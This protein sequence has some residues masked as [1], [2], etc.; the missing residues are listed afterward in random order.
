MIGLDIQSKIEIHKIRLETYTIEK[1]YLLKAMI[2]GPTGYKSV[3][4][5]G[6]PHACS[7]DTTLDR[8]WETMQKLIHLCELEEWAIEGLEKQYK[9]MESIMNG[10]ESIDLKVQYLRDAQHMRL[11]AIADKLV[12]SYD[13]IKEVSCRNPKKPTI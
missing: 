4:Y 2:G 3:S 6:M 8:S 12:Y 10:T 7:N 11:Q 9:E 5:E 1:E 13:Y